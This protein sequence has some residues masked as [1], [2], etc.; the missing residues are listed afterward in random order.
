MSD[1]ISSND[2]PQST[3][4]LDPVHPTTDT[5]SNM[6]VPILQ[7]A[8]KVSVPLPS[9]LTF[10]EDFIRASVGFRHIDSIK[11]HLSTLYQD[12][13]SLDA[14]PSD[15][16]M[17]LGDCATLRK[18]PR[19][20]IPVDRPSQFGDVIHMD[21]VFGPDISIG[22]IHYGLLFTDRYSRMTFI[23]PLQNLTF[24]IKKQLET[25]FLI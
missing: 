19:N 18:S 7:C 1:I 3:V 5:S 15:A 8:D 25:F 6:P 10:T 2:T 11:Q 12:T 9:R 22:N 21:I 23:Y 17:D 13:I 20:T 4:P 14:L 16:V 24:D